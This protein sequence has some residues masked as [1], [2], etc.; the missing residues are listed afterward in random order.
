MRTNIILGASANA[1][2]AVDQILK[3]L[4]QSQNSSLGFAECR[5]HTRSTPSVAEDSKA[6]APVFRNRIALVI[7]EKLSK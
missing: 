2:E 7:V 5:V 3:N 6:V 1:R 4:L